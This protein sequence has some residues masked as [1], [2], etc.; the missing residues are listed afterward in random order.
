M[1]LA[2][3][4]LI[5]LSR[6]VLGASLVVCLLGVVGSLIDGDLKGGA[7]LSLLAA[8]YGWM[9]RAVWPGKMTAVRQDAACSPQ[10][11]RKPKAER[12]GPR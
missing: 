2:T 12:P 9:L 8:V 11:E 7:G 5:W 1:H 6:L 4:L 3:T 10:P